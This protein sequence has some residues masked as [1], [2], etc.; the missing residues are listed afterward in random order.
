VDL[1]RGIPRPFLNG[2]VKLA[3][4][5]HLTGG[6][7]ME[8]IKVVSL[9]VV[10]T[11]SLLSGS[12]LTWAQYDQRNSSNPYMGMDLRTKMALEERDKRLEEQRARRGATGGTTGQKGRIQIQQP[13]KKQTKGQQPPKQQ[14]VKPQPPKQQVVKP[15]PPKQ[16]VVQSQQLKSQLQKQP[17]RKTPR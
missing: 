14:I 17:I 15:Q 11:G 13:I 10:L 7:L 4:S 2:V 9:T 3:P 6:R 8:R 1:L 12:T 5:F 16:Q